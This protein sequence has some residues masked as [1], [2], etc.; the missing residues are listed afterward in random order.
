M[1]GVTPVRRRQ[2]HQVSCGTDSWD[3][4]RSIRTRRPDAAPAVS[5][6][7][8]RP[9]GA[10]NA[11]NGGPGEDPEWP[12]RYA[13]GFDPQGA[14][15]QAG[16]SLL[17]G[18]TACSARECARGGWESGRLRHGTVQESAGAKLASAA[19]AQCCLHRASRDLSA[20]RDVRVGKSAVGFAG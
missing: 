3:R 8:S 5:R 15:R 10:R 2:H 6:I 18:F 1:P 14:R 20:G 9:R 17:S 4:W 19:T 13:G 12:S 7:A 16:L 11:A